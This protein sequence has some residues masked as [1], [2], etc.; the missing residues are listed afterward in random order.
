MDSGRIERPKQQTQIGKKPPVA[1]TASL[2]V[3]PGKIIVEPR[4]VSEATTAPTALATTKKKDSPV[5]AQPVERK[6]T[7][8]ARTPTPSL[9]TK[10]QTSVDPA[11][12]PVKPISDPVAPTENI[13]VKPEKMLAKSIQSQSNPRLPPPEPPG[14]SQYK[15][16]RSELSG[17]ELEVLTSLFVGAYE[18]GNIEE[19]MAL[20]DDRASANNKTGKHSIRRDY[21]KF[22][23]NTR[24]REI[25]LRQLSWQRNGL[26]ASGRGLY[27]VRVRGEQGTKNYTGTIR[28]EVEKKN[29]KVLITL[30]SHKS[31]F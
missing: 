6:Q 8:T 22:F 29:K 15:A 19:M 26:S 28:F 27:Q 20:F 11:P 21:E 9:M 14:T 16:K 5:V 1:Q 30:L 24:Q 17:V 13:T 7:S 18:R 2:I 25:R 3:E 10:N 4:K 12:Q 31:L 23:D